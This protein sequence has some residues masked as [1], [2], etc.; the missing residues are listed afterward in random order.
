MLG[1]HRRGR[2]L[3]RWWCGKGSGAPGRT[4]NGGSHGGSRTTVHHPPPPG[5]SLTGRSSDCYRTCSGMAGHRGAHAEDIGFPDGELKG[6]CVAKNAC[7]VKKW[8][9]LPMSRVK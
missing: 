2:A 7:V 4:D 5:A 8:S 6:A 3:I 1:F 9:G